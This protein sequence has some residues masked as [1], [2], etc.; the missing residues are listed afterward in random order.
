[1]TKLRSKKQLRELPLWQ[2]TLP[3]FGWVYPDKVGRDHYFAVVD[4][5]EKGLPVP[6]NVLK[7]YP[8]LTTKRKPRG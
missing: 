6:E 5:V 3:E 1:M 4:A 2:L 8:S 7:S